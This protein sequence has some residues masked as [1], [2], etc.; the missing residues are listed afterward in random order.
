MLTTPT[1]MERSREVCLSKAQGLRPQALGPWVDVAFGETP[2]VV[3][4]EGLDL[5]LA[6]EL[7]RRSG[8][9]CLHFHV[10]HFHVTGCPKPVATGRLD[11]CRTGRWS[12][13]VTPQWSPPCVQR[14]RSPRSSSC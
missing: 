6:A 14:H 9:F 13:V 10:T 7:K 12:G 8:T 2:D 4:G 5:R 11:A 3:L 1:S